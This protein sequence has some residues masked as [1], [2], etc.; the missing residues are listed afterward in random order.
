M[1]IE[2]L[3]VSHFVDSIVPEWD[4]FQ[5][6]AEPHHP[7]LHPRYVALWLERLGASTE[8]HLVTA[9][10]KDELVGY[11]PFMETVDSFGPFGVSTLRFVGNNIGFPGDIMYADIFAKDP[12]KEVVQSLLS[13][14]KDEWSVAKWNLGF[15]PPNSATGKIASEMFGLKEGDPSFQS[16]QYVTLDLPSSLEAYLGALSPSFRRNYKRRLRRLKEQGNLQFRV[17]KDPSRVALRM[18][19]MM[20]NHLRWWKGTE[21]EKWFGDERMREFLVSA[22]ELLATQGQSIFFTL[23]LDGNPISWNVGALDH[24][25][26]FEQLISYDQDYASFSPGML[27]SIDLLRHLLSLG[28]RRIELGPGFNERKRALGGKASTYLQ[29]EG[30]VSPPPWMARFWRTLKG[31]PKSK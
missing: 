22:A 21:R 3:E 11:A 20:Q 7:S 30:Y 28:I 10:E 15:M 24:E 27:L 2:E 1:R 26:Y 13:Y 19:E 4:I 5:R 8:S 9:W 17:D 14:A 25:R 31:R 23:E 12:R 18:R 16:K 6:V 29:I